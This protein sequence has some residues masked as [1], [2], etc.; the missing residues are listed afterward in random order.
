MSLLSSK[1]WLL[2]MRFVCY[3]SGLCK[4]WSIPDCN[5]V[6][7]LRGELHMDRNLIYYIPI[8]DLYT[9]QTN[10]YNKPDWKI[11]ITLPPCVI[12]NKHVVTSHQC[13]GHW[14][15]VTA[16]CYYIHYNF[17]QDIRKH[18]YYMYICYSQSVKSAISW[19]G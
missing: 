12:I 4:L 9:I 17:W 3:R 11:R 6:R 15:D 10:V 8:N 16:D 19:N 14:F 1:K 5:P 18:Y 13:W 2:W 7:T